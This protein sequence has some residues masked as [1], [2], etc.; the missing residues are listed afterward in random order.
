MAGT[1]DVWGEAIPGLLP[2]ENL[3]SGTGDVLPVNPE[4][5]CLASAGFSRK[6]FNSP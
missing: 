5:G 1:G 2:T 6:V 4:E 3:L